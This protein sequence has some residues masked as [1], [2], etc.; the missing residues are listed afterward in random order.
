MAK[1]LTKW[2]GL[3]VFA[4]LCRN[5]A[6]GRWPRKLQ[7]KFHN[8]AQASL[9][10]HPGGGSEEIKDWPPD[11]SWAE[12]RDLAAAGS[13][14]ELSRGGKRDPTLPSS[15]YLLEDSALTAGC[16]TGFGHGNWHHMVTPGL[17]TGKITASFGSLSWK[18]CHPCF[19]D[20]VH[21][22]KYLAINH[23]VNIY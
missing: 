8:T 13:E 9:P 23:S 4:A 20:K 5:V 6:S 10:W 12:N 18:W 15:F 16:E 17:T 2:G 7:Q 1:G 22:G 11:L 21:I 3:G 19:L 14:R